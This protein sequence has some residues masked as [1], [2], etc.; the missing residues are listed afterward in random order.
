[1]AYSFVMELEPV[2]RHGVFG[3]SFCWSMG[4]DRDEVDNAEEL[5]L[6]WEFRSK[7]GYLPEGV[8]NCGHCG[9]MWANSRIRCRAPYL[10]IDLLI[11]W[12]L[13]KSLDVR[14]SMSSQRINPSIQTGPSRGLSSAFLFQIVWR[15]WEISPKKSGRLFPIG[16]IWATATISPRYE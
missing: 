1:M 11:L 2:S 8:R 10:R 6:K 12:P 13:F 16:Q 7:S 5:G 3:W 9:Q 4:R 15:F 14:G